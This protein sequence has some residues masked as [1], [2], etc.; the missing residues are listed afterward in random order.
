MLKAIIVFDTVHGST[1]EVAE[2]I[3]EE[4][5]SGGDQAEVYDLRTSNP[6]DVSGD[7]LFVGSPTRTGKMT[8]RTAEYL[9]NFDAGPWRGRRIVAFDTVGPLSK[10][11]EKRNSMLQRMEGSSR[12]AAGTIQE[13]VTRRGLAAA[14]EQMHLAVTGMWGPLAPDA[15][16]MAMALA[17]KHLTEARRERSMENVQMA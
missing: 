6:L 9:E 7:I 11:A 8:R 2:A 5:R 14:P 1:G 4:I 17:R 12:T 13:A 3:A 10:D 15:R 16:D